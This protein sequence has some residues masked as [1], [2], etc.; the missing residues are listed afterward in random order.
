MSGLRRS[1]RDGRK[2]LAYCRLGGAEALEA[3]AAPGEW[4]TGL[5][6]V[7]LAATG[8]TWGWPANELLSRR[9]AGG[10]LADGA[11]LAEPSESD[12]AWVLEKP[13]SRARA[14]AE[15]F[16]R[17]LSAAGEGA[18]VDVAPPGFLESSWSPEEPAS[19]LLPPMSGSGVFPGDLAKSKGLVD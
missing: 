4:L 12:T 19:A 1:R 7:A 10:Q 5:G 2:C 16:F 11:D 17:D 14:L 3:R 9:L 18:P 6:S 8:Q 13:G 15:A